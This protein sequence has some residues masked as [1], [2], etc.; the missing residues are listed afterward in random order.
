MAREAKSLPTVNL[1][2]RKSQVV[3]GVAKHD[4]LSLK[5]QETKGREWARRNRLAVGRIFRENLSAYKPGVARPT[6]SPSTPAA[7][8]WT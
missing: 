7:R 6:R 1:L 3:R 8:P 4:I 5:A 2:L